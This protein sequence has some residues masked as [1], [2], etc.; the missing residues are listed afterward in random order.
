VS[1]TL[2]AA[3]VVCA[4]LG[5][6]MFGYLWRTRPRGKCAVPGCLD[7]AVTVLPATASTPRMPVCS[8]HL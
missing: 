7:D 2:V 4:L 8:R 5:L 1:C 6:T 3:G